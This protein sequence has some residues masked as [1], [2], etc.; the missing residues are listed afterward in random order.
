MSQTATRSPPIGGNLGAMPKILKYTL[1][2]AGALV[3][4][5]L[6][7]VA[8]V[9]AM[10]D[11]NDYKPLL[12]ERVQQQYQRTLAIP[13]RIELSFFPSL[14]ARLG[15]VSLSEPRGSDHFA[16]LT[17]AHVSLALLPLLRRQLVVD[18]ITVD[19][20]QLRL[21]RH[22]DGRLNID[23]LLGTPGDKTAPPTAAP[24]AASTAAATALQF[25]IAGIAI[26]NAAISVDDQ[27]GGHK[28][29]LSKA[30]LRTGRLT[31]G[32]PT[33]ASF[34]GHLAAAAPALDAE[35]SL[36]ARITLD[37]VPQRYA[38][39]D[40]ALEFTDRKLP[41]LKAGGSADVDLAKHTLASTL[42]GQIDQSRFKASFGMASFTPAVF[43]FDVD[44]DQIDLDRYLGTAPVQPAAAPAGPEKAFDL[45]GLRDLNA[46][47]SLRIGALQVA[48]L[49]TKKIRMELHAAGGKVDLNPV[50]A[51]LY[52]GTVAG[53]LGLTATTTP[54]LTVKQTL[55]G[56]SIGPLL[57]DATGKATL[58]GHGNVALD[59]N[60]QGNTVT[61]LKKALAG[62]ARLELR[63]GMVRGFNVAQTLRNAKAKLGVAQ[64]QQSGT[65]S[66]GEATDFS[67][68]TASFAIA[69]GV[70]HND[71]LQLS[72]PLLRVGGSGDVDLGES[73]LDYLVKATVVA[74]LEGQGGP[75]L[76]ALR[77][78]TVPVRL[79]GPFSSIG[80][81]ID[82]AG[83]AKDLAK[84][85][86]E[87]KAKEAAA[88]VKE[89]L[90]DKLKG[91]L[92]K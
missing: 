42:E 21:V 80:Y 39:N 84:G 86:V 10:F 27:Q 51:E 79:S 87:D 5:L 18:K 60:T 64:G 24:P 92:K 47:G 32:Q 4:L 34:K 37:P 68:M 23:D 58:E 29:A 53:S 77:G 54:R 13:G 83:L 26:G 62:S 38:V 85:Q 89:R 65:A 2:A 20:L 9:A 73:R 31:P 16:S 25:D 28:L 63:D 7:V 57:K 3:G 40:L 75:E 81:R 46:R 67:A 90:G 44:I 61:A 91:L 48:H 52:E 19:G 35:L 41:A 56:I 22:K 50:A 88:K 36:K 55:S 66:Q 1:V 69:G 43:R 82:F 11:P 17:S 71:D 30:E 6:I 14:G 72:T 33:D 74:T 45:S 70:A 59:V 8:I 78:Q 76:Q 49:Q 12:V 15:A